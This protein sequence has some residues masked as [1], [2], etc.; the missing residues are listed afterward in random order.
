MARGPWNDKPVHEIADRF[1]TANAGDGGED[2]GHGELDAGEDVVADDGAGDIVGV[3][4]ED[5]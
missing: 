5:E 3:A 2:D 1:S 4:F